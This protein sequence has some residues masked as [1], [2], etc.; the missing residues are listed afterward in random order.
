[1][2]RSN[3]TICPRDSFSRNFKCSAVIWTGA[4]KWKAQ[5]HVYAFVKCMQF[6]RDQSLIVVHA[7]NRVEF[8]FDRPMENCVRGMRPGENE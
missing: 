1:M 8:A 3:H 5:R 2:D 4:R 7:K 6:Q